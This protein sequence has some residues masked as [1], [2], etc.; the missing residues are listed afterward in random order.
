M[1]PGGPNGKRP[2]LGSWTATAPTGTSL[3][4]PH[5]STTPRPN[6]IPHPPPATASATHPHHYSAPGPYQQPYP[7]RPIDHGSGPPP[8]PPPPAHHHPTTP[9]QGPGPIPVPLHGHAQP[10]HPDLDRRQIEQETLAPMQDH[11]RQPAQP[12]HHHLSQPPSP[13]HPPYH[14]YHAPRESYIKR[15]SGDD[16]RRSNSAGGHA[17]DSLLHTPHPVSASHPPPSHQQ[18]AYSAE[19]QRHMYENGPS[20]PP[21]PGAYRPTTYPP[22]TPTHQTPYESHSNYPPAPEQYYGVYASSSSSGKKKNTRASQVLRPSL[23]CDQCRQL[24]AKCDETKPCKTCRDKGTECRY[25]D[26]VPKATD[27]AQADILDGITMI[28]SSIE[29]LVDR[30]GRL[31]DKM[32]K[33]ESSDVAYHSGRHIKADSATEED[34]TGLRRSP[35]RHDADSA[36]QYYEGHSHEYPNFT[37][38]RVPMRLMAE[39]EP[40]ADPGPPVPPGEPA[41]PINHTTLAGLLL[42][43]PTIRDLVKPHLESEGITHVT[44]YPI[45]QEQSRGVL[46]VYGRGEDCHPS[47]YPREPNPD[48]GQVD[49]PDDSSHTTSPSPAADWGHIGGLSP[50]DQTVEYKG[51][52]LTSD[53]TPEFESDK[54]WSYVDSFRANILNMHPII[55]PKVIMEWVQH[56]MDTLP[57][58]S[59]R[60]RN[61]KAQSS[62][63]AVSNPSLNM[64]PEAA[65][66]KRKRSPTPDGRKTSSTWS[67]PRSGR[68]E[69]SIHN[70]LVL[71]ILALGKICLYRQRVPDAVHQAEPLQHGSPAT[72]NGVPPSPGQGSPPN[73]STHSQSSGFP[74]PREPERG[75]QSRRSSIH[76]SGSTPMR[77]GMGLKKNYEVIPGLEYFA[78]ATDILGNHMGAYKNMKN[79]YALIFAGLYHG[80]LARPME[81]FAFIHQASHKLMVIMRPS[82]DKLRRSKQ[83]FTMIQ[84]MKYNQLALTFW[85]CLQ[86]ESDLIAELQ[87]PPS[88]L[89]SYEDNMPHPNMSL[90]DGFDQRTLD[91]YPAQL[92]LRTHLNSIHRMFYAPDKDK[93][94]PD[95]K[96]LDPKFNNVGSVADAVSNMEWVARSYA[97]K[98]E[99]PPADNILAARLRAKYWGAQVITYRPFIRQILQWSDSMENH[100]SSPSGFA[101]SEFRQG[102][103]APVIDP[104]AR[105]SKEISEAVKD[106]AR[107][108][109]KALIEST[110]AFHNLGSSRPIITNVFGTAHAQWGNLLVLSA[111]SQNPVLKD[112]VSRRLL[113]EL[114][115]K[116]ILFLQQSSTAT[117]SLRSDMNILIGIQRDLNLFDRPKKTGSQQADVMMTEGQQADTTMTGSF[118]SS[119]SVH[120]PKLPMAAP[121][122]MSNAS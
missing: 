26:P 97:F 79:V 6:P 12:Q 95:A 1:D 59:T 17:P 50:T 4:H 90:L 118:S 16:S 5:S 52:V 108:G 60:S 27:K 42:K 86:L 40:E 94:E 76:G 38:E 99:D 69:R 37:Q 22:P 63:F 2:R 28:H 109:I 77:G 23:A 7:P 72:R 3:P 32:S 48:H 24:K 93:K 119:T 75:F 88:G 51:G 121:Q 104:S 41:I 58:R 84:D 100:P 65:G 112:H 43:W 78:L 85:T 47:R 92:Y 101:V 11:F 20:V 35:F 61:Y 13:A 62:S 34:L 70:A 68:P 113:T 67:A 116:T 83:S 120:T 96:E 15:E 106:Y 19:G 80:Q 57:S 110:R 56:F 114:F 39:D 98:E 82:L 89:L 87:L 9:T 44:E 30:V 36:P 25:R 53:G 91:S 33:M 55:Q 107:R 102:V 64:P 31:E 14:Q 81:S 8:P 29:T 111:C 46:I 49:M 74:S 21:T 10:Q 103:A 105:S 18:A 45:S 66:S 115:D 122:P 73:F 71:T 54:V 117:S